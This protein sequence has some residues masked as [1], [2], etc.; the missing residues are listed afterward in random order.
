MGDLGVGRAQ[1]DAY[2]VGAGPAPLPR[3]LALTR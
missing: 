3:P 2:G 1:P